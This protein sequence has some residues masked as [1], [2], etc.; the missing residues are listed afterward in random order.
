[1]EKNHNEKL[2]KIIGVISLFIIMI[3]F[4]NAFGV[5]TPYW[6]GYPLKIA[7]GEST[8]VGLGLQNMVGE[9]NITLRAKITSDGDGIAS[10]SDENLDY[11][12]PLGKKEGV[13]ASIKISIPKDA[14]V[15]KI[16]Q[17]IISFKQ[18]SSGE[19][20]MVRVAGGI[21]TK[22]PVEVVGP[23]E[24]VLFREEPE[25]KF[26]KYLL[27]TLALILIIIIIIIVFIIVKRKTK[28]K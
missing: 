20:G 26:S 18:V 2:Q 17:I 21:T 22:F 15:N 14:E 23:E 25:N 9:E 6:D 8:T 7:P 16:Y 13:G 12:V 10:L 3:S 4:V 19:G 24:S 1:M 27:W 5:S 28:D 11:F